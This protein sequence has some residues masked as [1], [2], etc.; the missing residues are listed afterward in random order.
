MLHS[1]KAYRIEFERQ[2]VKYN[3][4]DLD[5]CFVAFGVVDVDRKQLTTIDLLI[6]LMINHALCS[7]Y[8]LQ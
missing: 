7:V 8:I 3:R 2:H 1:R 6:M 4:M 5:N